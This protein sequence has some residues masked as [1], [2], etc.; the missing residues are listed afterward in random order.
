MKILIIKNIP[1]PYR[2]KLFNTLSQVLKEK[3]ADLE[4]W[5]LANREPNRKWILSKNDFNY[6]HRYFWGLHPRISNMY[7]HFNPGIY[8]KLLF[9]KPDV[10][11]IGGFGAPTLWFIPFFV[12]KR[13]SLLLWIETNN[14]RSLRNKGIAHFFKTWLISKYQNF[15]VPG[16]RAVDY[17]N[18]RHNSTRNVRF[19]K[20]PNLIDET[21]FNIGVSDIRKNHLEST[22]MKYGVVGNKQI[23]FCPARLS[24]EKGLVEFLNALPSNI[25][26]FEFLIAG[27]G[28]LESEIQDLINKKKLSVRLLGNKQI[29]EI[30]ELF[31]ISNLF[32]LPS[33]ADASPLSVIEAIAAELP[34]LVSVRIGNF[35]EVFNGKNGWSL[36]P[37]EP[38]KLKEVIKD[39]IQL[40]SNVLAQM[41]KESSFLYDKNFNTLQKVSE[42]SEQLTE[43]K[44]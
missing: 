40:D 10:I 33:L 42:F 1:S 24:P 30:M 15:V 19:F 35:P 11:I 7:A 41:G 27:D 22:R 26:S 4:V 18:Q 38:E 37:E 14:Y 21:I 39:I 5:Y 9:A 23:W 6:N 32:V 44:N 12:K 36:D 34:L 16:Q 8:L 28:P 20:L 31:A 13:T 29:N 25:T 3:E 2:N 43:L 17:I